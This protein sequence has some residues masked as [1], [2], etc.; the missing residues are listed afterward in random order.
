M[1]WGRR[2]ES[3]S[4]AAALPP[5]DGLPAAHNFWLHAAGK[6]RKQRVVTKEERQHAALLHRTHVMC[7]VARAVLFDAAAEQHELQVRDSGGGGG[8]VHTVAWVP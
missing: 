3:D 4:N 2:G 1:G 5:L 6:V 7:L 8:Q